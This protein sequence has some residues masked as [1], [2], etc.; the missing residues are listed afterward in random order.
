MV[1]PLSP[2]M[3]TQPPQSLSAGHR[4]GWWGAAGQTLRTH[5]TVHS[6][7]LR[8]TNNPPFLALALLCS[9]AKLPTGL[10]PL[11]HTILSTPTPPQTPTGPGAAQAQG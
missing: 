6:V 11:M 4:E 3:M 1:L 9:C 8:C 2:A 7:A 10:L 5:V